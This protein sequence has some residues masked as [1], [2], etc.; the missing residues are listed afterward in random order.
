MEK[1]FKMYQ[2]I[3]IEIENNGKAIQ[4]YLFSQGNTWNT[5]KS[6]EDA[7]I[8]EIN[9]RKFLYVGSLG[10]LFLNGTD[11]DTCV[12]QMNMPIMKFIKTVSYS[13][14]EVR[15]K[16]CIGEKEYYIDELEVALKNIKPI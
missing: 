9:H 12:Y 1:L 15:E 11:S 13:L 8:H 2:D 7:T 16:I 6:I 14:E 4:E 5:L 3:K 10:L